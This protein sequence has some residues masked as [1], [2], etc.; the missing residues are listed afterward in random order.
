MNR[1][2]ISEYLSGTDTDINQFAY[3]IPQNTWKRVELK[4]AGSSVTAIWYDD[5]YTVITTLT[6]TLNAGIS[7]GSWGLFAAF[8]AGSHTYFQEI[9]ARKYCSPEPTWGTW[10]TEESA[11]FPP[12][13]TGFIIG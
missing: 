4:V 13:S 10:G 2:D 6:G 3:T 11:G 9:L 12:H 1:L 5:D 8:D 7:S